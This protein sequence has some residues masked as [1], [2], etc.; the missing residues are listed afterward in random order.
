MTEVCGRGANPPVAPCG[1]R[2]Y[3]RGQ[4][5]EARCSTPFPFLILA[6]LLNV[7]V[8]VVL[9]TFPAPSLP[10]FFEC[11]GYYAYPSKAIYEDCQVAFNNL[12]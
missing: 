11:D 9:S 5:P 12:P 10:H 1:G 4:R 3:P 7:D 8:S 6:R 2:L